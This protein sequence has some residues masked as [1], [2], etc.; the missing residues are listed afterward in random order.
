[1]T[2]PQSTTEPAAEMADGPGIVIM[3]WSPRNIG[4]VDELVRTMAGADFGRITCIAD[5]EVPGGLR[6]HPGVDLRLLT[7]DPRLGSDELSER[8]RA[9][10]IVAAKAVIVLPRR[11]SDEPDSSS[12]LTCAAIRRACDSSS[13][14]NVLV[15][16]ED[17]E[18]AFEFVGLGVRRII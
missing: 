17:P 12:R 15:E 7:F 13:G 10:K 2:Q 1:M 3:H 14:P 9:L 18:A 8:L 4:L 5:A 16:V 11:G 6:E